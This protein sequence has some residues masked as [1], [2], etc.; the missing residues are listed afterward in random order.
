[1]QKIPFELVVQEGMAGGANPFVGVVQ[2]EAAWGALQ[3]NAELPEGTDF[4][5]H[6]LLVVVA[7]QRPDLGHTVKILDVL[8]MERALGAKVAL[9][10]HEEVA[11]SS[12]ADA[13]AHQICVARVEKSGRHY[14]FAKR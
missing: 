6:T 3:V 2:S 9:V 11:G 13:I 5:R 8:D 7:G 14:L 12:G 4:K 1:M 10:L